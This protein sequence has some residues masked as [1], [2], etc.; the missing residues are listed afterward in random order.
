MISNHLFT[1]L[2][3]VAQLGFMG[4]WSS[5]YILHLTSPESLFPVTMS[6]ISWV[7]SLLN[8]GRPLGAIGGA[9][10]INYFGSKTA[11]LIN[12]VP[13]ALSWLFILLA[14]SVEWLYV[15]RFLGGFHIGM[16]YGCYSLYLGEI[17]D[18]SNRGALV[19][20]GTSGIP[21]GNFIMSILG[22]Y[23]S[24]RMSAAIAS[25]SCLIL[26]ILFL[27]LPESPHHLIKTNQH[28]KA[29]ASIHWYHPDSDVESEFMALRKFI[30]SLSKQSLLDS[31]KELKTA[32]F[33][34]TLSVI[35]ILITYNQ[36]CGINSIVFY[37]ESILTMARISVIPPA[38]VVI[39]V[40]AFGIVGSVLSM[41]LMDRLGRKVLMITS[42][43]GIT[44]SLVLV[45]AEFHLLYFGF[46]PKTV[47]AL[48]IVGMCSFYMT[49][50]I[51]AL[52]VPSAI[53][54]EVF[55]PHLKCIAACFTTSMSGTASF[56][57]T[58]TYLPMLEA[59]SE[60]YLFLFYGLLIATAVPFTIFFVPETK[61]MSLQE[62]QGQLMG[63]SERKD[64]KRGKVLACADQVQKYRK[65]N[66]FVIP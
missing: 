2:L 46:E 9:M 11:I 34:K 1:V 36:L 10:C 63:N 44:L 66:S 61:G 60:R 30:E 21:I 52:P 23:L 4:A 19:A 53:L 62:I 6:E 59:L 29:K 51:G 17:A 48:S 39:V 49:V 12:C 57:S 35:V 8:I 43:T 18:S 15:A 56:I 33:R 42:C 24:M 40:M 5:P 55:P 50:F 28:E 58:A 3:L 64:K 32:H 20:L 38:Q 65:Q 7:V 22:A 14:N 16:T 41:F 25:A 47:E 37:M 31:L 27:W 54:G 45:T 26:I 13:V